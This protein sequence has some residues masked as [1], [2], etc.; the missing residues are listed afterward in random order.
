[1]SYNGLTKTNEVKIMSKIAVIDYTSDGHVYQVA[2]GA[3]KTVK[4]SYNEAYA[5][6]K[7]LFVSGE[8]ERV[9]NRIFEEHSLA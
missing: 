9:D 7:E 2:V 8:V 6:A 3:E 1:M 5:Y 4:Q